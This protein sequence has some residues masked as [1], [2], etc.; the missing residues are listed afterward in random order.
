MS[1]LRE[2][3]E[4]G[5][6]PILINCVLIRCL[7]NGGGG[8]RIFFLNLIDGWVKINGGWRGRNFKKSVNIGNE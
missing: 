5:K 1:T 2:G 7:I 8:E 6:R 4:K 3:F